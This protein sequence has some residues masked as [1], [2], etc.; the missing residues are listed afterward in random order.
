ML[1]DFHK[2]VEDFEEYMKQQIKD[3][4]IAE[5]GKPLKCQFCD[6]K[7]FKLDNIFR[8]EGYVVKYSIVCQYCG[9]TIGTWAYGGWLF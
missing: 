9:K 8:E 1:K 3:G 7:D 5:N 4:Y 2:H 6:S